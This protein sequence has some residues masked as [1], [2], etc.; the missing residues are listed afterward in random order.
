[1]NS[2]ITRVF[3][4]CLICV[5]FCGCDKRES[6]EIE[7][8]EEIEIKTI[9]EDVSSE[10]ESTISYEVKTTTEEIIDGY[11]IEIADIPDY[12]GEPYVEIC[13]NHAQFSSE[14]LTLTDYEYYSELDGLGRCGVAMALVTPNT[15]PK[16]SRGEIGSV[17][18]SGWHTVKY[19]EVIEDNYLYNRCHLIAY[20]LT[21]QNANEKN[22]ITGTRYMNIVGMLPF[23]NKV[24]EYVSETGKCVLYRTTPIFDGDNLV[25]SGVTIEAKSVEDKGEGIDFYVYV[26]NVQPNILI[27]YSDGSSMVDPDYVGVT[28]EANADETVTEIESDAQEYV[29]N[30]N[31]KRFHYPYCSSVDQMKEKNRKYV[32][33]SREELLKQGYKSCGNCNP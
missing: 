18:P 16:E 1:M 11:E 9:I 32:N 21:G 30:T 14:E 13:N 27:D 25:A 20:E 7:D 15:L 22:L 28:T 2:R 23:E 19:N 33:A 6:H 29:L 5:L 3:L 24:E 4:I 10:E 12:N 26:Y 31:T 8:N 17:K